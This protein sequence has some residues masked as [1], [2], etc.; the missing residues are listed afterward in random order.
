MLD[1]RSPAGGTQ[2]PVISGGGRSSAGGRARDGAGG[3]ARDG[4]GEGLARAT[5]GEIAT[6]AASGA[7]DVI[8]TSGDAIWRYE[9]ARA[10]PVEVPETAAARRISARSPWAPSVVSGLDQPTLRTA[11][12]MAEGGGGEEGAFT[13]DEDEYGPDDEGADPD[14]DAAMQAALVA[15]SAVNAPSSTVNAQR[16]RRGCQAPQE[17]VLD[18]L[19]RLEWPLLASACLCLPLLASACLCLPLLA[20][21]CLCL[22]LMVLGL[23]VHRPRLLRYSREVI[24]PQHARAHHGAPPP[25]PTGA[26][27]TPPT[28]LSRRLA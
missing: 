24:D 12:E 19:V 13:A 6:S 28:L 7:S 15:S 5:H 17:L 8:S 23:L 18:L 20:S 2:S 11:L 16:P 9:I 26:R 25:L 3:S 10:A 27:A 14:E 4:A 22:P 21:A 1:V